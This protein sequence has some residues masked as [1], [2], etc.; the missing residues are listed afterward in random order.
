MVKFGFFK[1]NDPA[2]G[3][4]EDGAVMDLKSGNL[5]FQM[6]PM[7]G[8]RMASVMGPDGQ[9]CRVIIESPQV[10]AFSDR[11]L[12]W[13]DKSGPVDTPISQ[14]RFVQPLPAGARLVFDMKAVSSGRTD[15]VLETARGGNVGTL[16]V[17]VKNSRP[18]KVSACR[19]IDLEFS[20]PFDDLKIR[21]T[22][23]RAIDVFR[24]CA[25][26]SLL[27]DSVV[28]RVEC[29]IGLGNPIVLGRK[30]TEFNS[31]LSTIFEHIVRKTPP[32]AKTADVIAIYGWDFELTN[33]PIAG[34][35]S[36][37]FC[38]VEFNMDASARSRTLEHEIGHALKLEHT[39]VK[40]IMNGDGFDRLERFEADQIEK[41]NPNF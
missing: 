33:E 16:Q 28:H 37:K 10:V 34:L 24:N 27:Y 9:D 6:V 19:L 14:D 1:T 36:G 3:S 25:N 5:I 26:V 15:I 35:N 31:E 41:L 8:R 30:L 2:F 23:A 7:G 38:F 12:G 40:S 13:I 22:M 11:V 4:D 39:Q 29:D 17:T 21:A 18:V 20:N 32:A